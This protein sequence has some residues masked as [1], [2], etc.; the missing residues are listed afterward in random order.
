MRKLS[1]L[2][3]LIFAFSGLAG[4]TVPELGK[5]ALSVVMPENLEGLNETQLSKIETKILQI[6]TSNGISASGY[7]HNFVIYPKFSINDSRIVESGM[8]DITIL[9]CD[10]S[11]FIKQVDNNL[12]FSSISKTLK[13]N[14]KD[15]SLAITSAI[16]QINTNDA[17]YAKFID[18]GKNKILSYY[19]S[20]CGDI[21][22]K[23]QTMYKLQDFDASLATLMSVPEEATGCYSN[24]QQKA[25]EVYTAYQ[26][27][28]CASQIQRA[29]AQLAANYYNAALQ[30][31]SEIDPS[32]RC[33]SEAQSL[34]KKVEPKVDEDQKRKWDF[35]KQRYNDRVALE[36]L[37]INAMKEIAVAYY[38]RQPPVRINK[39]YNYKVIVL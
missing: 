26:N 8:Q 34:I 36:K 3:A 13:G 32:T 11:L 30:T 23:A 12:V 1:I 16:N 29:K 2:A 20:K 28:H 6:V 21:I 4:Q 22:S 15:K 19:E 17:D 18:I 27:Q 10:I 37:R 7:A 39:T 31:L 9:N 38:R 25:F 14:G 5:I 35:M 33:L 24:I